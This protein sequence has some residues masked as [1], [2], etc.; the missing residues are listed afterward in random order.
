MQ[1]VTFFVGPFQFGVNVLR[2]QEIRRTQPIT[3][4]PVAPG[5]IAGL[6]NL[7][8]QILTALDLRAFFGLGQADD[9]GACMNVIMPYRDSVISLVVDRVGDVVIVD[10]A[11]VERLPPNTPERLRPLL[12]GVVP[13]EGRLLFVLDADKALDKMLKLVEVA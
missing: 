1:L 2:V 9:A 7:R 4:V 5:V 8:G 11:K 10:D 6:L 12:S 13:G 3:R